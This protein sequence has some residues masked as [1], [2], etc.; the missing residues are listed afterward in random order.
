MLKDG[1]LRVQCMYYLKQSV[2]DYVEKNRGE[3][4][5]IAKLNETQTDLNKR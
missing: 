4:L 2:T 5:Y 1:E 3:C